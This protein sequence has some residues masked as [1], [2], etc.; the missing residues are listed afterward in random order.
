MKFPLKLADVKIKATVGFSE[1][2]GVGF[3]LLGR[4][5][6]FNKFRICFNDKIKIVETTKL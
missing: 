4:M 6:F 5:D 2:L 3:N 1:S